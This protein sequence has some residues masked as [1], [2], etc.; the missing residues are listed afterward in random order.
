M[1][2]PELAAA[3][4]LDAREKMPATRVFTRPICERMPIPLLL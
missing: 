3:E 2:G 1:T 4:F